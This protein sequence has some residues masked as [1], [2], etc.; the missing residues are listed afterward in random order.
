M[1]T[2]L[3][4]DYSQG[5]GCANPATY[6]GYCTTHA[7]QRNRE[8]HTNKSIYN[9]KRWAVLRRSVLFNHPLCACGE[10]ATDVHHIKDI[11]KGGDPWSRA[12]LMALCHPC[13]SK[14]TRR[15]HG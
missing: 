6:R 12:N 9:S 15:D 8:T 3:C 1:P 11:D 7:Q 4:S 13:H 2:R 5:H 14:I 10:I